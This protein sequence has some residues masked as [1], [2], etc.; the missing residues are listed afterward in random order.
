MQGRFPNE[1]MYYQFLKAMRELTEQLAIQ[2]EL[3][4]M[5]LH[6]SKE[7]EQ[8]FRQNVLKKTKYGR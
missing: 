8:E 7:E 1:A 5:E 3:R 4:I 2:N 6:M